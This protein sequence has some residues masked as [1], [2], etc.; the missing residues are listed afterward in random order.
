[1]VLVHF[2]DMVQS[3]DKNLD[4]CNDL[5]STLIQVGLFYHNVQGITEELKFAFPQC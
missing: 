1:M 3:N 4:I 5:S 2:I